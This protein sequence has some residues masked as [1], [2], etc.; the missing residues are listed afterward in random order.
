M[1]LGLA[2][3]IASQSLALSQGV[4]DGL[5]DSVGM[6]VELHVTQHH[7]GG[8]K[9][10]GGVGQ[11]LASNVRG[12]A[13]DSLE[14]GA[15]VTNVAGG[16]ETKTTDE[17]G[18]HVGENV[19]VQ[20]GHDKD[21]VVVRVGIGDHLQA[22]VVEEL[23]IELNVGE[24]LGDILGDVEEETVR[25]LHDGGLVDDAD[26]LAADGLGVLEGV[27]QDTL[28]SLTGDE[29]DGLDNA[30]HDDVLNAR[31]LA[32][33]VLTDQDGVD[34]I[35]RGLVAGN[36]AARSEVGEEVECSAEGQ[37][38]RDVALANGSLHGDVR[39]RLLSSFIY[40]SLHPHGREAAQ[41][42][43]R[44]PLRAT[45]FLLMFSMAASGMAVLP[46]LRIGVTSTDSQVMGV[47]IRAV[48]KAMRHL[49]PS[50]VI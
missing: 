1:G 40:C 8:E 6:V 36:R 26:L 33:S 15:L 18:A 20:V 16:G 19:T 48:S 22:G 42:T 10:S 12:R 38:K 23:G 11:S 45:L 14:D 5:L 32:L 24:V 44:G 4:E 2:A 47:W 28:G 9:E 29:L 3:E 37:V 35:V 41:L 7:D 50:S 43:A 27:A 34:I 21:L 13:V 25:H 31:V 46:S 17:T 49:E 39:M 30:V